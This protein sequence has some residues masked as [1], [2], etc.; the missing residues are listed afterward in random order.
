MLDDLKDR[1]TKR[2]SLRCLRVLDDDH[3]HGSG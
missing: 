1:V 3:G 2:T